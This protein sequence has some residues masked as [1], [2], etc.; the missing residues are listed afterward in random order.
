MLGTN[1]EHR[2]ESVIIFISV[3]W[4]AW[5]RFRC[6]INCKEDPENCIRLVTTVQV[7]EK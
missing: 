5:E 6:N 2:V 1:T 7:D 3:G 4:M